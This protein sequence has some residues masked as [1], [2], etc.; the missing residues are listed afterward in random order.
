[1][2]RSRWIRRRTGTIRENIA[3]GQEDATLDDIIAAAGVALAHNFIAA[4][5][6]GYDTLVGERGIR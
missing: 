4:M 3:L 2:G 1:M 6:D 5:P